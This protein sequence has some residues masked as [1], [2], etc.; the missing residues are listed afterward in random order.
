[1][2]R[3]KLVLHGEVFRD[4]S[5][6][7]FLSLKSIGEKDKYEE[8][9]LWGGLVNSRN[10]RRILKK[11]DT[12]L[13]INGSLVISE[14]AIN[15]HGYGALSKSQLMY[16]I[17]ISLNGR[18]ALISKEI[19]GDLV[20]F[21]YIKKTNGRLNNNIPDNWSFGIIS[22]GQN[23]SGIKRLITSIRVQEIVNYEI[24]ICG[25]IISGLDDNSIH[26][27]SDVQQT[28]I[29]A[30]ISK[31]KNK[32][33]QHLKYA[34]IVI[35]HDRFQLPEDWFK[36]ILEYHES[37]EVLCV[38]NLNRRS[39]GRMNDWMYFK[40]LPSN[41]WA[42]SRLENSY[43][44]NSWNYLPGGLIIAKKF[45]LESVPLNENLFWG[46]LEDVDWSLRLKLS[47]FEI[48]FDKNN[49]VLTE[50]SRI[51]PLPVWHNY[52]IIGPFLLRIKQ[53]KSTVIFVVKSSL[54]SL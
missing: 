41:R 21:N 52:R 47:G 26:Y 10:I 37:F 2:L 53:L 42:M 39:K 13:G 32:L 38:P 18:Y 14:K 9:I 22:N 35:L 50:S 12:L 31:K 29:R 11:T 33:V 7:E 24:L 34:N 15:S 8:C 25:P 43:N 27:I 4:L 40:G 17:S 3:I 51:K 30:P 49:L 6:D 16:E 54:G 19:F 36:N 1:M 48:W 20:K 28:D 46:E 5:E 44:K 45:V 23:E